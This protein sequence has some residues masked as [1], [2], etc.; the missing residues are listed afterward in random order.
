MEK[1]ITFV[2]FEDTAT[3]TGVPCLVQPCVHGHTNTKLI[4]EA[5]VVTT[6]LPKDSFIGEREVGVAYDVQKPL[7]LKFC[8]DPPIL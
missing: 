6:K 5:G 2:L 7:Q 3:K 8:S 1:L 4:V